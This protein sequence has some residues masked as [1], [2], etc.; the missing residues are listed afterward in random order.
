MRAERGEAVSG[1]A[2]AGPAAGFLSS[3]ARMR[4]AR[5]PWGS[6]IGLQESG[7]GDIS[8]AGDAFREAVDS[9]SI[10]GKASFPPGVSSGLADRQ[11]GQILINLYY[12]L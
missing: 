9:L 6:L 12:S 2:R 4:D 8:E 10:P 7:A 5:Q 1:P 3:P 11:C